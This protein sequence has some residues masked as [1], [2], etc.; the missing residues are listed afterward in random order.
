MIVNKTPADCLANMYKK[1]Q[2][3]PEFENFYLPFGG[4]LK[5]NNRWVK[6]AKLIPWDKFEDIYAKNFSNTGEG[7]PAKS[8]RIALGAL[9]IKERLG[10]SDAE[11]VEQICENPYLQYFLGFSEFSDKPPF[12]SSMYVYFRKRFSM[13]VVA[14]VNEMS[15]EKTWRNT[16]EKPEEKTSGADDDL[17]PPPNSGKLIVDATC[18]PADISY[19]LDL[20]LLNK[21][22]EKSEVIIDILYQSAVGLKEKPRTDKKK[23][24]KQYLV[25]AKSKRPGK[26]KLR[27][28]IGQQL[29]HLGRNLKHIDNL[30]NYTT[31]EHLSRKLY[32]DLL[33]ISEVFRQQ[34]EMFENKTSRVDD[35]I[36][37]IDQPHVRPIV[38]GKAGAPVEFGAKLSVSLINGYTCLDRLSRGRYNEAGDLISQ[39]ETYKKRFGF[40]P[41]SVHADQIYRNRANRSYCKDRGIRISGPALGRPPKVTEEN[42][43]HIRQQKE[44]A[45]QDEVDRIAVEGKFGQAKRRFGLSRI[46]AK[47]AATSESAISITFLVMNLVKLLGETL[48][49][50]VFLYTLRFKHSRSQPAMQY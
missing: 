49:C 14:E 31:L 18:A 44:I 15:L 34:K 37:S 22:R 10:V 38:R 48:F 3:H 35:R 6:L 7:A 28:A 42:A 26:Q 46:M 11:A 40:Y 16:N 27:K 21:A 41:A 8:A 30:L 5:S 36:V 24:R 45:Y 9:I 2:N 50:L 47:P 43:E 32:K 17:P 25:V 29:A 39:I 13:D 33:V 20:K 1:C 4:K 19:P 23:A 12:N